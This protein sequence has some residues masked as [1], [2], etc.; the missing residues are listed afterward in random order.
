MNLEQKI[1]ELQERNR[2]KYN[3]AKEVVRMSEQELDQLTTDTAHA[4]VK[5]VIGEMVGEVRLLLAKHYRTDEF[6]EVGFLND[7]KALEAKIKN[8]D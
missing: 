4:V 6:D 3:S 2:G 7:L 1:S 5:A 8:H